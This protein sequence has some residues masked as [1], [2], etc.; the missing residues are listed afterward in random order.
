VD[1]LRPVLGIPHWAEVHAPP[2]GVMAEQVHPYINAPLSVSPF[3]WGQK[4]RFA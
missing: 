2:I 1:D 3:I 4:R